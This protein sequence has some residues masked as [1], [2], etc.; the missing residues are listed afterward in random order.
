MLALAKNYDVVFLQMM[1]HAPHL[2]APIKQEFDKLLFEIRTVLISDKKIKPSLD[3]MLP[4]IFNFRIKALK[5]IIEKDGLNLTDL[6]NEVYPQLEE[7]RKNPRLAILVENISFALRCNK[8]VIDSA[9]TSIGSHK[10]DIEFGIAQMPEINYQQFIGSMAYAILDDVTFQKFV[11]MA[12]A[13]L[14]IEFI[15]LSAFII[16]DEKL[17]VSDTV[18]KELAFLISDAAQE[19]SA[20]AVELGILKVRPQTKQYFSGEVDK[21]FIDEQRHLS[22]LG[23]IDFAESLD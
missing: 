9:I 20:T 8:R 23:L 1:S 4:T 2:Q 12:H 17:I 16:N 5:W 3:A 21:S 7:L 15:I 19:Y 6:I 18:I 11:E 22:E 14:Y 10:G 13:S